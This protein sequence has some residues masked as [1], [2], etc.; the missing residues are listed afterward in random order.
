M[1]LSAHRS[2]Q[3]GNPRRPHCD[4]SSNHH[5]RTDCAKGRPHK[6]R[7]QITVGAPNRNRGLREDELATYQLPVV[8][9]TGC[10]RLGA[11]LDRVMWVVAKA[12]TAPAC[13]RTA[14]RLIESGMTCSPAPL[15][16]PLGLLQGRADIAQ[17][18]SPPRFDDAPQGGVRQLDGL[19]EGQGNESEIQR[20][21]LRTATGAIC[22][23]RI[24]LTR[25]RGFRATKAL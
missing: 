4:S 17:T 11:V 6:R 1:H 14:L 25:I 24:Y 8:L 3:R 5:C 7:R 9:A 19:P 22:L 12:A 18:A 10:L 23:A 16:P 2:V 21:V 20:P 15:R 13:R